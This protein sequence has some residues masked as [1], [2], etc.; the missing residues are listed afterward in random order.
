VPLHFVNEEIAPGVKLNGGLVNHVMT[1]VE[2]SAWQGSAEFIE[3]DLGALNVGDS[4]HA[5]QLA[6]P[7][8]VKLVSTSDDPSSSASSSKGGAAEAAEGEAACRVISGTRAAMAAAGILPPAAFSFLARHEST[9]PDR[10][11]RQPRPRIRRPPGTMS[12]SGLSTSLAD[13]LKTSLAPQPKFFGK[14]ARLANSGCCNRP[15]S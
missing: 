2:V 6:L 1:E 4:I 15:P 10:R 13:K 11:P 5:S 14:A 8:G 3:V 9:P 7:K 12:A